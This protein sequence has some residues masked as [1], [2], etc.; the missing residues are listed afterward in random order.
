MPK[1]FMPKQFSIAV[2]NDLSMLPFAVIAFDLFEFSFQLTQTGCC[3]L[4]LVPWILEQICHTGCGL[5]TFQ[6]SVGCLLYFGDH[7]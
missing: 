2:S 1:T 5:S 7:S 4:V 6:A 3:L